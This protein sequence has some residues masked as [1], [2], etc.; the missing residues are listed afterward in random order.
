MRKG[1]SFSILGDSISTLS[2]YLPEDYPS[3]YGWHNL[4]AGILWPQQTWWGQVID[5]F[6]GTLLVNNSW[7]GSF[8]SRDPACE[9]ESYGC[10][11]ARTGGLGVQGVDPE[12]ILVFLGSNDKGG[13][14]RLHSEDTTDLS[15]AANAYNCMLDKL[16]RNYPQARIWCFTLLKVTGSECFT[17][18]EAFSDMIRQAA[19]AHGCP[20]V[21]LCAWPETCDTVDGLHPNEK[22]MQTIAQAVIHNM[23]KEDAHGF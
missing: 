19:R 16:Q 15:V 20:V 8:V 18:L 12:E 13:G 14:V 4:Q 11:D 6:G 22:G 3:F 5:H 9:I 2:G 7:S 10:S 17:R 23:Q 21:D 1:A